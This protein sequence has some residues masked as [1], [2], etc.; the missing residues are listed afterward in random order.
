MMAVCFGFAHHILT[1]CKFPTLDKKNR[2]ND[3]FGL[4]EFSRTVLGYVRVNC[5]KLYRTF[6]LNYW[7]VLQQIN[8]AINPRINKV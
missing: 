3:R 6:F 4:V 2:K 5:S 1:E 8:E 7:T